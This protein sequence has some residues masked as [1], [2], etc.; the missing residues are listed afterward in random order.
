MHRFQTLLIATCAVLL[1]F[2][3]YQL[4]RASP[5]QFVGGGVR[6][7]LDEVI[8]QS[9]VSIHGPS[10]SGTGVVIGRSGN[11]YTLLTA[12]HVVGG[13]ADQADIELADGSAQIRLQIIKEF[14][15][16]DLVV[17]SFTSSRVFIPAVINGFLPYPA[18][19]TAEL[20]TPELNLRSR[21]DT[22]TNKSRVAGYSLPSKAIR[23]RLFRVVD[24][25]LIEKIQGNDDGYNLLYQSSTVQGMSGGP[26]LGFRDCSNGKGFALGISPNSVFPSLVAIHGRSEDYR[27]GDGRSGVSLGIPIDRDML[28]FLRS[29]APQRGIPVGEAQ[30]RPLVNRSSCL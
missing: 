7:D 19:D 12:R 14:T 28:N 8:R 18:P 23:K 25:Q 6:P 10:G 24:A 4:L 9:V 17:A 2:S 5:D 26:V 15:G 13:T 1:P 21:F 20:I 11:L 3:P 16:I 30:I 27:G 29:I 22:V